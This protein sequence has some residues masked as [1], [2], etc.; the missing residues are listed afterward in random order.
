MKKLF[1]C[2]CFKISTLLVLNLLYDKIIFNFKKF[3]LKKFNLCI[4]IHF[5]WLQ[6]IRLNNKNNIELII[7]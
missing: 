5:F 7:Y 4:L 3:Y 6:K 1:Y 2:L